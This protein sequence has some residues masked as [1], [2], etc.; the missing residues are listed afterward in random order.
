M[1]NRSKTKKLTLKRESL[2]E[3]STSQMQQ[4]AGGAPGSMCAANSCCP[5]TTPEIH[6]R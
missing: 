5:T 1:S 6:R 2:R 3:L 4:V